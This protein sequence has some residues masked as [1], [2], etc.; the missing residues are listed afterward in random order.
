[1]NKITKIVKGEAKTIRVY[2]PREEA[3]VLYSIP[4]AGDALAW[5]KATFSATQFDP[6]EKRVEVGGLPLVWGRV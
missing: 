1:M 5:N 2:S 6:V 4:S 3:F